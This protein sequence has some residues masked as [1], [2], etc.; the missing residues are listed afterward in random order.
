MIVATLLGGSPL[1]SFG[2]QGSSGVGNRTTEQPS[3]AQGS[4]N[5][6]QTT[7]QDGEQNS[8]TGANN[9]QQAGIEPIVPDLPN[10]GA[11]RKRSGRGGRRASRRA[12]SC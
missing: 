7:G 9:A 4:Q 11:G 8:P 10:G 2:G 3:A 6:G 1:F 12:N 5:P